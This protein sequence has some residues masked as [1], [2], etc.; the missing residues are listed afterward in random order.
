MLTTP[1]EEPLAALGE[2]VPEF[3]RESCREAGVE[4]HTG[5]AP[6]MEALGMGELRSQRGDEIPTE[7][8]L[9]VPPHK[10]PSALAHL[11]GDGPL[12]EVSGVFE[13]AEEGLSW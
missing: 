12:V 5:F 11:P 10:R 6:D 3:L 8:K 7:V 9:V 2:G 1:E 4:L 13:T